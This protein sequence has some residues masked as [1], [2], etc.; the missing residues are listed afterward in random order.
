MQK[1]SVN[2][3]GR[4]TTM[5]RRVVNTF[6]Q[7]VKVPA[8]KEMLKQYQAQKSIYQTS[9]PLTPG[10]YRL[11]VVAKDVVAGNIFNHELRLDVPRLKPDKASTSTVVLADIIEPVPMKSIAIR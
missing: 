5:T 3:F 6:E 10:T 9:M 2:I 8:P 4:V 11:N 7:T 1:A